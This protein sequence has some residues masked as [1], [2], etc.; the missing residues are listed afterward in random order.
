M[1]IAGIDEAGRGPCLG[2]LVVAVSVLEKSREEELYELGVKDSKLLSTEKRK[3][4]YPKIKK[5]S[6][7]HAFSKV[8]AKEL[9]SL[10]LRKSLNEIEAMKI[11]KML[12]ELKN[13][14]EV[15]YVDSPDILQD[16]FG[17]R[18]KKYLSFSPTIIA[19]HKADFN[20]AVVSAASII[21]K[22]ER[23]KEIERFSKKYGR[24]GSG[25]PGDKETTEFIRKYLDMHNSLP[26]IV[27]MSWD[28]T[29]RILNDKYQTKLFAEK[30]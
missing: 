21:A 23:D 14:P 16:N 26:E 24:I 11:A 29:K 4:F 22:V 8:S 9:D 6:L 25:Y 27:R 2:P 17:K 12:N 19:E 15:L 30:L 3:K 1:L 18:L 28:T 5:L 20:Y 13:K 7:E 10:M